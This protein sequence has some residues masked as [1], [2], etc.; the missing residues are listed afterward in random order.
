MAGLPEMER[1]QQ[2][3]LDSHLFL[4]PA[5]SQAM[6]TWRRSRK[7]QIPQVDS[8]KHWVLPIFLW[9]TEHLLVHP[10]PVN[11]LLDPPLEPQERRTAYNLSCPTDNFCHITGAMEHS[12]TSP[13]AQDS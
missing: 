6:I 7:P 13:E 12:R 8:R 11:C 4:L 1:D 10:S 5:M 3:R 2:L 9:V